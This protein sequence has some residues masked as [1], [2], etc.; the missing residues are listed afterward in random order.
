MVIYPYKIG[1]ASA[2]DVARHFGIKRVYPNRRFRPKQGQLIINWGSSRIPDWMQ[3][4]FDRGCTMLNS[5]PAVSLASNKLVCFNELHRN[6]VITPIFFTDPERVGDYANDTD[7]IYCRTL[8]TSKG[9]DGIILASPTDEELP[10]APLYTVGINGETS[11][12]RV[13][14]FNSQVLDFVKKKK[15]TTER[16]SERGIEFNAD[17]RNHNNGWVFARV[18]IELP[19][20]V[21]REAVKA[22]E[23]LGLDFGAVDII[24]NGDYA[25]VLEVNTAPGLEG[26]TFNKYCEVIN[27]LRG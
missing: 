9:G 23:A 5:P 1:S 6:G 12:Y 22:I 13:H 10:S 17:I 26:T 4:V 18:D 7:I 8:L 16:L 21:G 15:M 3:L 14:V 27:E 11:E 19:D 20:Y 25:S 2:R 24:S